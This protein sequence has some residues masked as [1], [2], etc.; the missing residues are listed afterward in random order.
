MKVFGR[1]ILERDKEVDLS[2]LD[3]IVFVDEK[4]RVL[5]VSLYRA[6]QD[7]MLEVRSEQGTINVLPRAANVVSVEVRLR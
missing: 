5:T 2:H 6:R 7:N 3:E 1:S 4:G